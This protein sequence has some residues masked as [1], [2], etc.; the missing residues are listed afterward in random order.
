MRTQA[1]YNTHPTVVSIDADRD[2]F[3]ADGNAV[4]LN[5]SL[6]TAE[7]AR[8]QAEWD[9]KQYQRDRAKAYP[10]LAEQFDAIFHGGIDAWKAQIQVVKDQFPKPTE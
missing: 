6:I 5:E 9:S 7:V 8:L 2:A 3:D 1:I 10:P 4:Q